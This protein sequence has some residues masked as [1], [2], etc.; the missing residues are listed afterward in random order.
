MNMFIGTV[1]QL[2]KKKIVSQKQITS[3]SEGFNY[4]S[5]N[6]QDDLNNRIDKIY[7]LVVDDLIVAYMLLTNIKKTK[8]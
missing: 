2:L 8:T 4:W 6:S 1:K 3:L 5:D 7:I